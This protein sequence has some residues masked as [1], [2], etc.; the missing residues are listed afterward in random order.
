MKV[1]VLGY[2]GAYPEAGE[3]TAG[4]LLETGEHTVLV[5]CG[6]GVLAQL[7]KYIPL[8]KLDAVILS[9]Y[10]S[11]HMADVG[12]LQYATLINARLGKTKTVLPLY[13]H[14]RSQRFQELNYAEYTVGIAIEPG[15]MLDISGLKVHFSET[16]H[17]EYNLAMRFEYQGK[18]FVYSGDMGYSEKI[19]PFLSQTDLFLCEASLYSEQQGTIPG[20]LSAAETAR[21][22]AKARVGRLVLT[23]FP[24][25]GNLNDL[26]L[27]AARYYDGPLEMAKCGSIYLI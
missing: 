22:A 26:R 1:T 10:H 20:H 19:I 25:Y 21:L 12:C 14:D 27:Q 24:H 4:Y 17:D 15:E 9:H 7:Q 3:A 8:E 11:D 5:D 2:W 23:H 16:V 18:R 6:S 13:G